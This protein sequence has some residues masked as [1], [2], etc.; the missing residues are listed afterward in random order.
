MEID[1]DKLLADTLRDGL[2][3][4]LKTQLTRSYQNPLDD[5][6]KGAMA[7]HGPAMQSLLA[8][9]IRACLDDPLFRGAVFEQVRAAVAK[10]LVQKFGG[11]LERT[12]NQLKSDPT[13]RARIVLAIEEIVRPKEPPPPPA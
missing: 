1:S 5:L 13:T 9:A 11:E 4:G 7:K 3:E 2:R 12:V 10:Q 8:D 6:L